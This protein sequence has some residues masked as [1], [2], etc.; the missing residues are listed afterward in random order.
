MADFV[1]DV[2]IIGG[3]AAGLF[4]AASAPAKVNG[5]ILDKS[6]APGRKLLMS[7]AGQCNITHGGSIKDFICRYGDNGSRIR[8]SLYKFSNLSLIDFFEKRGVKTLE[9]DDGKVFPKSMDAGTVLD[10]LLSAGREK[11]FQLI[12]SCEV[13]EINCGEVFSLNSSK[14]RFICRKLIICTGGCSYPSTGS[15]GKFFPVLEKMGFDIIT[16]KPALVPV[17]VEGYPYGELSGVSVKNAEI[18]SGSHRVKGDLLFTHSNFSGPA[19]LHISRYVKPGSEIRICFC[20]EKSIEAVSGELSALRKDKS[21]SRKE[22]VT[23]LKSLFPSLP[24]AFVEKVFTD[25]GFDEHLGFADFSSK[26][27]A[28]VLKRIFSDTYKVSGTGGFSTAM[29][30]AGGVSLKEITVKT[31]ESKKF[32]GLYFAGEVLDVDGDTGGYN[33]QFAFSSGY[34]AINHAVFNK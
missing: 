33:L 1:Y 18:S 31:G 12:S 14:G 6:S 10:C 5:L 15:D 13:S 26:A 3:G 2:I 17:S 19:A 20:T 25:E 4:A 24:S 16:P 28:S 11:G 32:P 23:V 30:T 7:G 27:A 34:N 9:R 8:A 29:A 22:A 21:S